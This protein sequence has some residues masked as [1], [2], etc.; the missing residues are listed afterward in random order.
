METIQLLTYLADLANNNRE[1]YHQHKEAKK[2]ATAVFEH[3][4]LELT[5][6]IGVWENMFLAHPPKN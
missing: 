3:I 1:W 4:V 2:A 5:Q 6:R